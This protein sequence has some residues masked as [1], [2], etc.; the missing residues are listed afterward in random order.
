M[1]AVSSCPYRRRVRRAPH[2]CDRLAPRLLREGMR[3]HRHERPN[4][5]PRSLR[6]ANT[7]H[8]CE[9]MIRADCE[10]VDNQHAVLINRGAQA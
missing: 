9:G 4:D 10:P 3:S 7:D 5:R 8:V 2:L 6:G 1:P